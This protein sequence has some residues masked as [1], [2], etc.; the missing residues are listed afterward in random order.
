[1]FS[2]T[3]PEEKTIRVITDTDAKNEADD[4]Y[5]IVHTLLSPRFDNRS[6]IAAHFGE[7]KSNTSMEDSF[8]EIQ[9]ILKLMNWADEG[10]AVRGAA[11]AL[12][13]E[14]T[15]S[16]SPGSEVII[17]E[18]MK[19]D[20]RPLF[21]TFLGPLTDV[22]SAYLQEPRIAEKVTV[23]W[24]GGGRYPDGGREYNLSNDIHAA[25]VVFK[26]RLP[27]WQVPLNV[28]RMIMVSLAELES[29]VKP[30]GQIGDYL[31]KQL[32]DW[33]HT[34]YGKRSPYRTGECWCLGDMPVVG[35]MLYEHEFYY[36]SIPAPEFS[37]EMF[38]I[39]GTNHR[40]IRVYN[41]VDSRFILEDFYAKLKL[42][43]RR[44]PNSKNN[45]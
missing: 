9:T 11:H 6:I 32:V 25:N 17:K 13:D 18:A 23:I 42:F 24:I 39:H 34:K 35:L 5:A 29:R 10:L 31:F 1:M 2:Y 8:R 28:Y 19:E 20:T 38:Y 27:V 44:T 16:P 12:P 26:S 3:V 36:D 40:R 41:H 21:I 14:H 37:R 15:P 30:Y 43:A 4:Q 7:E 22:A 45:S 33:G